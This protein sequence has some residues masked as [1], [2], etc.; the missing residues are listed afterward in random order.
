MKKIDYSSLAQSHI[1]HMVSNQVEREIQ[2]RSEVAN[3]LDCAIIEAIDEDG[4]EI[5]VYEWWTVSEDFS[6]HANQA[7]EII[8][9][10]PFGTVWGRQVTM[11]PVY[12]DSIVQKILQIIS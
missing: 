5:N 3:T 7:G 4:N 9:E 1:Y 8:V 2:A 11:Q 10:T 12:Q 6:Y